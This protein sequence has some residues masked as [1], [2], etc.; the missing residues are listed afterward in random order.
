MEKLPEFIANHLFLVSLFLGLLALLL[1][2]IFA[3]GGAGASGLNP[4]E[5]TRLINH[6]KG[7]VL[8]IRKPEEFESGHIIN[9]LNIPEDQLDVQK[10]R[11]S[12]YKQRPVII[13]CSQGS[14]APRVVRKLRQE[15]LEKVY[16]L[17]SGLRSWRDANLPLSKKANAQNLQDK[18]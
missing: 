17:K 8:D 4:A 14:L 3:T 13:C 11:W 2:N 10:Q 16:Y 6:E 15:G 18:G 9:A 7:V 12:K 1:W 5:V